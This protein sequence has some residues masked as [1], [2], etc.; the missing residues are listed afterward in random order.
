MRSHDREAWLARHCT[1]KK[2]CRRR[3][4]P[5]PI[6]TKTRK[7]LASRFFQ[8][9]TGK[10][11]TGPYLQWTGRRMDN[12]CWW[13]GSRDTQTRDHLF[14]FCKRA[15]SPF[16]GCEGGHGGQETV[17]GHPDHRADGRRTVHGGYNG[18]PEHHQIWG[19][20]RQGHSVV[21][22]PYSISSFLG[23]LL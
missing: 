6:A 16:E 21:K 4:K 1:P 2:Y 14:K 13:C 10:A 20:A 12:K 17:A 8:L 19:M 23:P 9:R 5:D 18:F 7:S 11:P 22:F 3:K 15:D